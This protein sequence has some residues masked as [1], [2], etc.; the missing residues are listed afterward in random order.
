MT[1][2][3]GA[4]D[5]SVNGNDADAGALLY[6]SGDARAGDQR[7]L[8]GTSSRAAATRRTRSPR[9]TGVIP[10]SPGAGTDLSAVHEPGHDAAEVRRPRR[11]RLRG[12]PAADVLRRLRRHRRHHAHRHRAVR[13]QERLVDGLRQGELH[14]GRRFRAG[15]FTNVLERRRREPAHARRRTA[16]PIT[17]EFETKT[18]R[19][20]GCATSA[21]LGRRHVL[22]YG[23]NFRYNTFDLSL[24]PR[25]RQPHR[26]RR[27]RPGRDL[28]VRHVPLGRRRA[29]RSLRLHRRLRVLAADDLHDQAAGESARSGSRTTAPIARRR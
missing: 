6:V 1:F 27:L 8:G 20:R 5:R 29:R 11:L 17:F 4:F 18:Y 9:P 2:G 16:A 15:F 24:A 13:H 26:V 28:P 23:G 12:R 25:R 22:S 19:L 10:G 21:S 14:A 7:S 3:I